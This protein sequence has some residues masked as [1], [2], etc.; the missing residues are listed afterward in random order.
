MI[1]VLASLAS[2]EFHRA[3]TDEAEIIV[4]SCVHKRYESCRGRDHTVEESITA[5]PSKRFL[6]MHLLDCKHVGINSP[7]RFKIP[8][9]S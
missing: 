9:E 3:A 6:G 7:I 2:E 8:Y 5:S 4:R 1:A